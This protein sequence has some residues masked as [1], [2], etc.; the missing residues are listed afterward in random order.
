MSPELEKIVVD[1]H[2]FRPQELSPDSSYQFLKLRPR[3]SKIISLVRRLIWNR[4]CLSVDLS[5]GCQRQS[6]QG[7]EDRRDHGAWQFSDQKFTQFS[8]T[9]FLVRINE[10]CDQLFFECFLARCRSQRSDS[11]PVYRHDYALPH[12]WMTV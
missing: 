12:A 4:K 10:I 8:N 2:I 5:V 1:S 6:F 9:R 7:D 3:R 11:R